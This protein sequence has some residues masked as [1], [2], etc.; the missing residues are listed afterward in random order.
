MQLA[1]LTGSCA[2]QL[3]IASRKAARRRI[4]RR[5]LPDHDRGADPIETVISAACLDMLGDNP[6]GFQI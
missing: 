1:N 5:P 4:A 3:D 2:L 6:G